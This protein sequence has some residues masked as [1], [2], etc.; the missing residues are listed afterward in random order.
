MSCSAPQT[1][2]KKGSFGGP[3]VHP[4]LESAVAWRDVLLGQRLADVVI[5]MIHQVRLGGQ[6]RG[7]TYPMMQ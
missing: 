4:V 1:L 7:M 3:V 2:Y 6:G 5:P